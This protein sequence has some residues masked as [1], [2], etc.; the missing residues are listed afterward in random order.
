MKVAD[1]RSA[2]LSYFVEGG[3]TLVPSASLIPQSD[4]SLLFVNAGMVPFKSYFLGQEKPPYKKA[5]TAQHCLRVGGKHNDLDNVGKTLR[6][7]TFFEMLGNFSFGDYGKQRAIELAWQFLTQVL[8]LPIEKLWITVHHDDAESKR[9]WIDVVGVQADRVI[10]CG[11]ADNFWSMGDTGPCGPCTEI[12]YDHGPDVA[13]GPPGSADQDGDRFVEIWNIVFMEF[14][15]S[16]DGEM[17]PLPRLCVDTGMG[18]ER[19]AAVMQGVSSNYE[20]DAFQ[21][22]IKAYHALA[23][24]SVNQISAQVVADHMRSMC[25]LIHDGVLPSNEGRGYVL[26]RIIRRAL[27]FAYT[28]GLQLPCLYRL[29]P[30]VV[31]L[32]QHREDFVAL[33]DTMLRVIKDEEVAFAKTIDQGIQLFEKM[34]NGLEGETISGEAA[35]KLYDTYGFP[36]DLVVDLARERNLS[37]DLEGFD[38]CMRDQRLRSRQSQQF[39]AL[40]STDWLPDIVTEFTGYD[41]DESMG[42]LLCI[43]SGDE[44]VQKVTS[45]DAVLVFD[46]TPFYAE[47]GG[48]VGDVGLITGPAGRFNVVD[49]QRHGGCVVHYGHIEE[50]VLSVDDTCALSVHDRRGETKKN[51]SA[52]HLLHEALGQVLGTHVMQKGSLV[53]HERLRFDFSHPS[54]LKPDEIDQIEQLVNQAISADYLVSTDMMALDKAREEGVKAQFD[55]KYADQVR[56]LS[57]GTSRELCGGTHV[58]RT[59]EI[60]YFVIVEQTAVAQGIRRIEA[61]T[62]LAAVQYAQQIRQQLS[63]LGYLLQS[64]VVALAD[65]VE[66]MKSQ[67]KQYQKANEAL[68]LRS[69]AYDVQQALDHVQTMSS[70]S[71]LVTSVSYDSPKYLRPFTQNCLVS[72]KVDCVV[73]LQ[74][75]S[76]KLYLSVGCGQDFAKRYTAQAVFRVLAESLGAKGGGKPVFCQGSADLS[77]ISQGSDVGAIKKHCQQVLSAFFTD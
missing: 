30:I 66:K 56:V 29:V 61:L 71:V 55:E 67:L 59:G 69:M 19:I 13:G 44:N 7:H 50:G 42:K 24:R 41:A 70:A 3:H 48:Q 16:A 1:L 39:T 11:D 4:P 12:F 18:L 25:W 38:A 6:H 73:L 5:T 28:D 15:R 21:D 62:G 17:T 57:M 37:V 36:L 14:N 35:F 64:P 2:F 76:D 23:E 10:A 40:T 45:G 54:P 75:S 26:R 46:Q 8:S 52:T 34:L 9:L 60:G 68:V 22:L 51:H 43:R 65:K 77:S 33:Q 74:V 72:A 32:Y 47:S 58:S 53:S 63:H 31:Q 20:I 27:R 49:T